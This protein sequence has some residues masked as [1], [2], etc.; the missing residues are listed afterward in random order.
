MFD[1]VE[2]DSYAKEKKLNE[3]Y[4]LDRS[5][6]RNEKNDVEKLLLSFAL[7]LKMTKRQREIC[8]KM[9]WENMTA[10]KIAD[11]YKITLSNVSISLKRSLCKLLSQVIKNNQE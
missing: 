8:Y 4:Q 1:D 11:D 5:V 10:S 3:A 6:Q 9:L 7:L 2:L